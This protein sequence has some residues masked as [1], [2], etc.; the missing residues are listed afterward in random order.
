MKHIKLILIFLFIILINGSHTFGTIIRD[1]IG[2]EN[3]NGV[4]FIIHKVDKNET[5]YALSRRYGVK[6]N[7]ILKYNPKAKK[8]L[9]IGQKLE[10]PIENY[11]PDQTYSELTHI[12]KPSETLFSIS[13]KY[14]VSVE[15]LKNWNDLKSNAIVIGQVLVIKKENDDGQKTAEI[16]DQTGRKIVHIVTSGETLFSISNRYNVS[17]NNLR[18]WNNLDNNNVRIG[19]ELIV[20]FTEES[21]ESAVKANYLIEDNEPDDYERPIQ[22]YEIPDSD[23]EEE[24]SE[25]G[26]RKITE[27]G[28]ASVI[29]G[30]E[31]T[32]KYL[33]LHRTA[34]VGTI[35]QVRNEMNDLSVFV[36]V[37]GKLP[38]T[39]ENER[40]LIKISET[41]YER[42]R[43]VDDRFMVEITY[44][45]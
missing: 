14:D 42:L 1:S 17:I 3:I 7:E 41:A 20:D 18:V 21:G 6:A 29:E 22:T 45:P 8:G 2:V 31:S 23:Y 34:P 13:R 10:I 12:V 9:S 26:F 30:S 27:R 33:A 24:I 38:D 40:I 37:I 19:Q 16:V 5:V 28:N 25:D 39:G 44:H 15:D 43:A 35:I 11:T 4:W 36:R 32:K